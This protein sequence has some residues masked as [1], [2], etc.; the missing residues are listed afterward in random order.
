[1]F[2]KPSQEPALFQSIFQMTQGFILLGQL[3]FVSPFLTFSFWEYIKK[4][5][6]NKP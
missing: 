6:K 1:M 3:L 2:Q 4:K 5:K